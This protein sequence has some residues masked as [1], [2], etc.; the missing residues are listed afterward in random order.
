MRVWITFE[1]GRYSFRT[2]THKCFR[3]SQTRMHNACMSDRMMKFILLRWA[4][5]LKGQCHKNFVLLRLW[6]FRLGPTDMP[7]RHLT[8]VNCPF[9]LLGLFQDGVHRSKTEV[10]HACML[11]FPCTKNAPISVCVYTRSACIRR[12]IVSMWDGNGLRMH[13]VKTFQP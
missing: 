10:R 2:R 4:P 6:R 1:T 5:S 7:E 12:L 9:N 8:A 11:P 3:G 13:F